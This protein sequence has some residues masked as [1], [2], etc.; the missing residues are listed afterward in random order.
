MVR[1]GAYRIVGGIKQRERQAYVRE[2]RLPARRAGLRDALVWQGQRY[3]TLVMA[4][5]E[6]GRPSHGPH[7]R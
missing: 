1:T 5:L 4:V 6:E 7:L 2:V 3:D